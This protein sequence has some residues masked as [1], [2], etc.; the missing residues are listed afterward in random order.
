MPKGQTFAPG[1][2]ALPPSSTRADEAQASSA[3]Q[4]QAE[5]DS[6]VSALMGMSGSSTGHAGAVSQQQAVLDAT[7]ASNLFLEVAKEWIALPKVAAEMRELYK[8][9]IIYKASALPDNLMQQLPQGLRDE[10]PKESPAPSN[11]KRAAS[12]A[13][14]EEDE[15]AEEARAGDDGDA[16]DGAD[17]EVAADDPYAPLPASEEEGILPKPRKKGKR[18]GEV[19]GAAGGT[20]KKARHSK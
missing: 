1:R 17:A 12:A 7:A 5:S 8:V 6:L 13:A 4:L 19:K 10:L 9:A 16:D 3:K 11:K 2:A 15:E 14:A 20:S 18:K